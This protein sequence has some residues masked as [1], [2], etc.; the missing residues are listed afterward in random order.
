MITMMKKQWIKK[1]TQNTLMRREKMTST[2]SL[3]GQMTEIEVAVEAVVEVG[4]VIA[5]PRRP[6]AGSPAPP[7]VSIP[8][9]GPIQGHTPAPAASQPSSSTDPLMV[10]TGTTPLTAAE[11]GAPASPVQIRQQ[12]PSKNVSTSRDLY[13]T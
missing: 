12:D 2:S 11:D 9:G 1:K 4:M 6:P 13:T 3:S 7:D 5:D 8:A 10:P